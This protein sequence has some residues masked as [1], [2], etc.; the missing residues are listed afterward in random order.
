MC[1]CRRRQRK[2]GWPDVRGAEGWGVLVSGP[3]GVNRDVRNACVGLV[4]EGME[5]GEGLR[6]KVCVVRLR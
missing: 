5:E 4:G 3:D 2:R 1:G 6:G